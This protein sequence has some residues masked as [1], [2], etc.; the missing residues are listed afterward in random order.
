MH[1]PQ[2]SLAV[3]KAELAVSLATSYLLVNSFDKTHRDH[4][5]LVGSSGLEQ[6]V[7]LDMQ[8]L[9]E[10]LPGACCAHGHVAQAAALL[11]LL[12]MFKACLSGLDPVILRVNR[13]TSLFAQPPCPAAPLRMALWMML[14]ASM[15]RWSTLMLDSGM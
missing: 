13:L 1:Q 10:V 9:V 15:Y 3:I 2:T 7:K 14:L 11:L 5:R 4:D 12:C 8:H 6:V